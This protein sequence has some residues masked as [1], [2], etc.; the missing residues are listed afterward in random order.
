MTRHL[1]TLSIQSIPLGIKKVFT[2][3]VLVLSSFFIIEWDGTYLKQC[4]LKLTYNCPHLTVLYDGHRF[5]TD[6]RLATGSPPYFQK[7]CNNT[8]P[9]LLGGLPRTRLCCRWSPT[10]SMT[11]STSRHNTT[12]ATQ[13][14]PT[15][16][17]LQG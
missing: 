15:I 5:L 6:S 4:W 7:C 17:S 10:T 13:L 1:A 3:W 16:A 11:R 9:Y 14:Y 2:L 8:L 12:G